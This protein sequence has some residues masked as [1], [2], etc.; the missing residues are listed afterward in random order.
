MSKNIEQIFVANPAT[1][2]GSTDLI[3]LGQGGTVDAAITG[4][5]FISQLN[6]PVQQEVHVA[7]N[8]NDSSGNGSIALPY[9]TI[10][11]ALS[12]ITDSASTKPYV[13][14]IHPGTYSETALHIPVWVF[15]VGDMQQ[16]TKI[17]DTSGAISINSAAFNNGSQRIGFQNLNLINSTGLT[18]DFQAIGGSGSNDIYINNCQI[19][20]AVTFR[21][22]GSDFLTGNSNQIFGAYTSSSMQEVWF[23]G[24]FNGTVTYNT[25]GVTG[26]T[27]GP[28]LTGVDL[29]NNVTFT[30]SGA[31]N[32]MQPTLISSQVSGTL[33]IDQ[34]TTT[35]FAD[36]V[37]LDA[38]SVSQTNGGLITYLDLANNINA[39]Y[40]PTHYTATST[41]VRGNL[42]GIDS[43][44]GPITNAITALTGDVVATGPGSVAATIQSNVVTNAKLAQAPA[45]TI[46]GNNTG[47]T[48]NV[49]DLTGSQVTAL[50]S[51]MVGDS[52][53]GGTQGVVP[54]PP[55]GS[56]ASGDFLAAN[57][58]W[59]FVNQ[60]KPRLADF[61][62]VTSIAQLVGGG[63][64][65]N[66]FT[67]THSNG[68]NYALVSAGGTVGTMEMY[69]ISDQTSPLLVN[70]GTFSGSY[71]ITA[72][73]I[74]GSTYAFIPSSGASTFIIVNITNPYSWVT[75]VTKTV[76]GTAGSVY[77]AAYSN[78]YLY[79]ATQH[80]GL[81]VFDVGGGLSGGTLSAP[82]QSYQE[83]GAVQSFGVAISGNFVYTTQ[84]STSNPFTT[85]QI[86]S[87]A[88][89]GAGTLNVPSLVQSVQ[90]TTA[91]EALG[92]TISGTTAFVS[93]IASGV[94]SI[95][96]INIS[97]PAAMTNISQITP[98]YTMNSGYVGVASGNFLFIPSGANAT[99]GGAIDFY[100]ITNTSAP[101]HIDTI[102]S[103]L[104]SDVFGGIAINNGYIY[105]GR[106]GVSATIGPFSVYTMPNLLPV[107][108]SGLGS[109]LILESLTPNTALVSSASDQIIS[110]VTTAT[111]LSYVHGVTSS[112]QSQINA[113]SAE[114]IPWTVETTDT[115][116]IKNN[117]YFANSAGTITF[118]LPVTS[119]VGDTISVS[120]MNTGSMVVAQNAGQ[121][122]RYGNQ[123]STVGVTGNITSTGIGDTITI[124]C[125]V[126][127]TGFQVVNSQGQL[128]V[129]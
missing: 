109:T 92:L 119:A 36:A 101:I 34:A 117:G 123:I 20:G 122:I 91:G 86:K 30:S 2:V 124:V 71:N 106:Y 40:T 110:S 33:T 4:A 74:S 29:F 120:N 90:V 6:K 78:G 73:V 115:S 105:V 24:Y 52:G 55:A 67:F 54:A 97:N 32:T 65:E 21:G 35:L 127:N 56:Y 43:A 12:T 1:T 72:A 95:N 107:F 27:I 19:V 13:V 39:N 53:S 84:Y 9:L 59:T 38:S 114:V 116:L 94:N 22:R 62:L 118:T 102:Y 98:S 14:W 125:N 8:G 44:L 46:K 11:H 16:P 75:V 31:G 103:G 104:A 77:S 42:Q 111:E 3:Y 37:S 81:T 41:D 87:W 80:N 93:V 113:I 69:D 18:I 58:V 126:A 23:G 28:E 15:L 66:T 45:D 121:S 5:N 47:V 64:S 129:T 100:D 7:S 108:G 68:K 96:L 50:L 128:N 79:C 82:V 88:L 17:I 48:A 112:I 10:G 26:Q 85:R 76:T 25:L 60:S 70:S 99:N 63:H 57:G 89:T 51:P 49:A 83:G 61:S